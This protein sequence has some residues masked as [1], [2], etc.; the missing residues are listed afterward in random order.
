VGVEE[1][2]KVRMSLLTFRFVNGTDIASA[3]LSSHSAYEEITNTTSNK[4]NPS[5]PFTDPAKSKN[6]DSIE[7][8][9]LTRIAHTPKTLLFQKEVFSFCGNFWRIR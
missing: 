3:S 9:A 7:V 1:K 2:R 8:F 5:I 6:F 4:S